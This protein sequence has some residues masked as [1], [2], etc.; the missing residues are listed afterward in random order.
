MKIKILVLIFAMISLLS[1]HVLSQDYPIYVGQEFT[2]GFDMGVDTDTKKRDWVSNQNGF[3][4]MEYPSGQIWGAVFIT[5]GKPQDPPRPFQNFIG[6]STLSVEMK[7]ENGNEKVDIGIKDNM[8][9]DNGQETK[10]TITV[11]NDWEVY[12]LP[13]REFSTA[14][15]SHLYVV[16]EFVFGG[17]NGRTVYFKNVKYNR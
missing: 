8:D 9:P 10:R 13:L 16:I 2:T 5:I 14:D 17:T 3:M 12:E 7:G 15:L 6:Y 4:K 1:N 11:T